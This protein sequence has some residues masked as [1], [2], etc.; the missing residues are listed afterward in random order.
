MRGQHWT[1]EQ[2]ALLK[3]LYKPTEEGRLSASQIAVEMA[4]GFTRNAIIGRIHRL[5]LPLRGQIKRAKRITKRPNRIETIRIVRANSNSNAIRIIESAT[6]ERA[7]LRCAE[8]E[9]RNVPLVDLSPGGCRY[10]Y[11]DGPFV[12]CDH[13]KVDGQS[14]CGPHFELT[15]VVTRTIDEAVREARRRRMRGLNF[16]KALLEAVQ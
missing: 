12:F 13:P 2:D 10:P 11:G 16:R 1:P 15:R 6:L 7:K 3:K 4:C 5:G 9:P 8:V 14:Y